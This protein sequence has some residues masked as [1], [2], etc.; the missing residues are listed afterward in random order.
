M[1]VSL[2]KLNFGVLRIKKCVKLSIKWAKFIFLDLFRQFF[3]DP[4][5]IQVF[6]NVVRTYCVV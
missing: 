4:R 5:S 6:N 1:E 2:I 3:K